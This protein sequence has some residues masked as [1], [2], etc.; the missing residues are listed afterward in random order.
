MA[1]SKATKSTILPFNHSKC[2]LVDGDRFQRKDLTEKL[3]LQEEEDLI[4]EIG[5]YVEERIIHSYGF[6]SIPIPGEDS[7]PS[8][9]ILASSDWQTASKLLIII[10]N[11]PGSMMGIFSRSFC[12]DHGLSKGSML[13]YIDRAISAEYA[14][15]ILRPNTNSVIQE[16]EGEGSKKIPITGSE[17]PEIHAL[18]VWENIICKAESSH[19]ALLGYANGAHL[20]KDLYLNAVV[21]SD[22]DIANNKIKAF[23]TIEASHILEDDDPRDIHDALGQIAVNLECNEAPKG[24]RLSYRKQKLGCTSI[25]LGLPI[26]S[27]EVTNVAASISLALA[28]VFKYLQLA[29]GGGEVFRIFSDIIAKD[30]GHNPVTAN[31]FSNPH[32]EEDDEL[33]ALPPPPL[34]S[35]KDARPVSGD[36]SYSGDD[37]IPPAPSVSPVPGKPTLLRRISAY[38]GIRNSS[39]ADKSEESAVDASSKLTVN[40]F[41]LLKIVGKGAF[42]KVSKQISLFVESIESKFLVTMIDFTGLICSGDS[43]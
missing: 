1:M 3:S 20:M 19:I 15:I 18:C 42:G 23:I 34:S 10:Q 5:H 14:V 13:P 41:D 35:G 43:T 30:N 32:S 8:T 7:V 36:K 12:I 39:E 26:G 25:S 38:I 6:V 29:E 4:K 22:N 33:S 24:Y 11:S 16:I 31:I 27:T 21:K 37:K 40:D 9:S 17:S 2:V 28:P